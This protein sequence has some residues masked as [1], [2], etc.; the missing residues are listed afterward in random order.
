MSEKC[1]TCGQAKPKK[2]RSID[3]HRRFFGVINAACKN[4]PEAHEFQP[5]DREHLRAWLLCKAGFRDTVTIPCESDDPH[6]LKLA[7]LATEAAIKAAK[8]VAFVRPHGVALAVFTPKSIKFETLDQTQFGSIRQAVE[9]IIE[10]ETGM[11]ADDL[12]K[13]E[14]AAA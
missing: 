8:N 7:T 10:A 12:L 11:K 5:D 6:I 2:P 9:E 4:W 3:D 13:S 14:D 1:P